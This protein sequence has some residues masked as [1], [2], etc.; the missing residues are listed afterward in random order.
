MGA[1]RA[2]HRPVQMAICCVS[3][4]LLK[5]KA[6]RSRQRWLTRS[7]QRHANRSPQSAVRSPQSA[8]GEDAGAGW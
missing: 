6:A 1:Q 4:R 5:I 8:N 3:A 2:C 7:R